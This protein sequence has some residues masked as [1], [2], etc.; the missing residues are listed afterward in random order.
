ML[1]GFSNL[2]YD[3]FYGSLLNLFGFIGY[4]YDVDLSRSKTDWAMH[5]S[6]D[7]QEESVM[8]SKNFP[9]YGLFGTCTL[10]Y[11]LQTMWR[12]VHQ[13]PPT[14]Q[15]MRDVINSVREFSINEETGG[16]A[17]AHPQLSLAAEAARLVMTNIWIGRLGASTTAMIWTREMLAKTIIQQQPTTTSGSGT[18]TSSSSSKVEGSDGA[19]S[20]NMVAVTSVQKAEAASKI[21]KSLNELLV[22]FDS[23]DFNCELWRYYSWLYFSWTP[24]AATDGQQLADAIKDR[25]LNERQLM[26]DV[27]GIQFPKFFSLMAVDMYLERLLSS[28]HQHFRQFPK[29]DKYD[30]SQSQQQ[31]R[32]MSKSPAKEVLGASTSA[33]S[34]LKAE[35][36]AKM[37]SLLL[38]VFDHLFDDVTTI[39]V[40]DLEDEEAQTPESDLKYRLYRSMVDIG[41]D[42]FLESRKLITSN[43]TTSL[44]EVTL[45]ATLVNRVDCWSRLISRLA[46]NVDSNNYPEALSEY[47]KVLKNGLPFEFPI[48]EMDLSKAEGSINNLD[49]FAVNLFSSMLLIRDNI[50]DLP[51]SKVVE[52]GCANNS[53][54]KLKQ[55]MA[56]MLLFAKTLYFQQL[57]VTGATISANQHQRD[58]FVSHVLSLQLSMAGHRFIKP[59]TD[60]QSYSFKSLLTKVFDL[61]NGYDFYFA[62]LHPIIFRSA[63][64]ILTIFKHPV[65]EKFSGHDQ[66]LFI[67][68]HSEMG[69]EFF[70]YFS[71]IVKLNFGK[72]AF[73]EFLCDSSSPSTPTAERA[74]A[75][76]NFSGSS[77][78]LHERQNF[79]LIDL[80]EV[81][82]HRFCSPRYASGLLKFVKKLLAQADKQPDDVAMTRIISSFADK[83][84][85]RPDNGSLLYK[86][87]HLVLFRKHAPLDSRWV[88]LRM[89]L[90]KD[91]AKL[92]STPSEDDDDAIMG[93]KEIYL[94]Y[95]FVLYSIK[96]TSSFDEGVIDEM[97][98]AMLHCCHR[99]LTETMFEQS[100]NFLSFTGMFSSLVLLYSN[101]GPAA[102]NGHL[103]LVSE[104]IGW[105]EMCEDYF[106][107]TEIT[108]KVKTQVNQGR[109]RYIIES[110]YQM[111]SY[112]TD[113][114]AAFQYEFY[115]SGKRTKSESES[116]Q[117]ADEEAGGG[118]PVTTSKQSLF[119]GDEVDFDSFLLPD[120]NQ[121]TDE[122]D[123]EDTEDENLCQALCTFTTTQKEFINQHWYN[124]HTCN[125]VD[126]VGVCT[127]CAQ[128]CHRGH[129]VTYSKHGSF[130]C[131]CGGNEE[132]GCRALTPRQPST[133]TKVAKKAAASAASKE[134][135]AAYVTGGAKTRGTRFCK[136]WCNTVY[137]QGNSVKAIHIHFGAD[138]NLIFF[139]TLDMVQW[140]LADNHRLLRNKFS[141]PNVNECYEHFGLKTGKIDDKIKPKLLEQ[142]R[143]AADIIF[144]FFKHYMPILEHFVSN[145]S[146]LGYLQ[147]V[148]AK[149]TA[150]Q[151][152]WEPLS[153]E[154]CEDLAS[155]VKFG[156]DPVFDNVQITT[157]QSQAV[158]HLTLITGALVR[159]QIMCLMRSRQQGVHNLLLVA[160]D[161]NRMSVVHLN[162]LLTQV[163]IN[164]SSKKK[165]HPQKL[166]TI[167]MPFTIM[168]ISHNQLN[169]EVVAVCGLK[170]CHI[171]AIT[172][173]GTVTGHRALNLSLDT[174]NH[175]VKPMWLPDSQSELA[176]VTLDFIKIFDITR[177]SDADFETP[178]YHFVI[179]SRKIR[180]MTF[181]YSDQEE[182]E[183]QRRYILILSGRAQVYAQV[184]GAEMRGTPNYYV[185]NQLT[186]EPPCN[187]TTAA[188][189]G[190]NSL[191]NT[192]IG[193]SLYYSHT[194]QLL[195]L[196]FLNSETVVAPFTI[197]NIKRKNISRT[198]ALNTPIGQVMGNLAVMTE[199]HEMIASETGT[200]MA[201][202]NNQPL[203]QWQEV[204]EHP[205]LIFAL[206]LDTSTPVVMMVNENKISLQELNPR[207]K[208]LDLVALSVSPATLSNPVL[209]NAVLNGPQ[210]RWTTMVN[211][212]EDGSLQIY[213]A[214]N[215]NTSI[216]LKPSYLN[217]DELRYTT[218]G[219]IGKRAKLSSISEGGAAAN[220]TT[221]AAGKKTTGE[222]YASVAARASSSGNANTSATRAEPKF[223]IDFFEHCTVMNDIEFGGAD[224]SELYNSQQIK[225]RLSSATTYIA[226]TKPNGFKISVAQTGNDQMV[227]AGIRV[228]LGVCDPVR[229]PTAVEV[230]G[231]S[232]IVNINRHRWFDIPFTN[233]EMRK[234]MEPPRAF[235]IRFAPSTDV[236][237]VTIV[238]SLKVY[239]KPVTSA[240]FEYDQESSGA[241]VTSTPTTTTTAAKSAA[242]ARR[243]VPAADGDDL[244]MSHA[245]PISRV[246]PQQKL[247]SLLYAPTITDDD[248]L[249]TVAPYHQ[250]VFVLNRLFA[251]CLDVLEAS[252]SFQEAA[253]H[254]NWDSKLLQDQGGAIEASLIASSKLLNVGISDRLAR[255]VCGL[256]ARL[257]PARA[258]YDEFRDERILEMTVS[259][260]QTYSP[261]D[262]IIYAHN[263]ALMRDIVSERPRNFIRLLAKTVNVA[264]GGGS[265]GSS[266]STAAS[267]IPKGALTMAT[268]LCDTFWGLYRERPEYDL[269]APVSRCRLFNNLESLI[270]SLVFI[271]YATMFACLQENAQSPCAAGK[272][273]QHSTTDTELNIVRKFT[274]MMLRFLMHGNLQIAY[275]A[276]RSLSRVLSNTNP[277]IYLRHPTER[278]IKSPAP[279]SFYTQST[280]SKFTTITKSP[281]YTTSTSTN[282]QTEGDTVYI[283]RRHNAS[284]NVPPG[285]GGE[286]TEANTAE[287]RIQ[288]T[289]AAVA[290]GYESSTSS[291]SGGL[292]RMPAIIRGRGRS[293]S[294]GTNR[295]GASHSNAYSNA[296]RRLGASN[297]G[298][299][300]IQRQIRDRLFGEGGEAA[301]RNDRNA[302]NIFEPN[303]LNYEDYRRLL[304]ANVPMLNEG[305]LGEYYLNELLN[306][307]PALAAIRRGSAASRNNNQADRQAAAPG[308]AD[309]NALLRDV[310]EIDFIEHE[311]DEEE[312][313]DEDEEGND[314]I[315]DLIE[316][317]EEDDED[318]DGNVFNDIILDDEDEDVDDDDS[319]ADAHAAR[320]VLPGGALNSSPNYVAAEDE[321]M[322]QVLNRIDNVPGGNIDEE[323]DERTIQSLRQ[324]IAQNRARLG[325]PADAA[326]ARAGGAAVPANVRNEQPNRAALHPHEEED[327]DDEDDDD[328]ED[329]EEEFMEA[330]DQAMVELAIALSLQDQGNAADND[331]A[332][333]ADVVVRTL[334]HYEAQREENPFDF[335][336]EQMEY[337]RS[338]QRDL[339]SAEEELVD[340][341]QAQALQQN[342]LLL[343]QLDDIALPPPVPEGFEEAA[344]RDASRRSSGGVANAGA[345]AAGPS[346]ASGARADDVTGLRRL[347]DILAEH[348]DTVEPRVD[349][350][351]ESYDQVASPPSQPSLQQQ[352]RQSSSSF[353]EEGE[354]NSLETS[355]SHGSEVPASASKQRHQSGGS[356]RS[357]GRR[358]AR[359]N[360]ASDVAGSSKSSLPA[361]TLASKAKKSSRKAIASRFCLTLLKQMGDQVE[362]LLTLDGLTSIPFLQVCFLIFYYY[363]FY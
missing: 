212:C 216:W 159:R 352:Q 297:G 351:N 204:P 340:L 348:D 59:G 31:R 77:S 46:E 346:G 281:K 308:A 93:M 323:M 151:S 234:L 36:I 198:T 333:A 280:M 253:Q 49:S 265:D 240:L 130:F 357:F 13:L 209:A 341:E 64:Y 39:L 47:Q 275:A 225:N 173:N 186:M 125:M 171:L 355:T 9:H 303:D 241:A 298:I 44:M 222:G 147:R 195:F 27:R 337:I 202:N 28:F 57:Q 132:G 81:T 72:C 238:D 53:W 170:E 360:S 271:L 70:Y 217:F 156:S 232:K 2:S 263:I 116:G 215:E 347:S 305:E 230:F 324:E 227:I 180:D 98:T 315:D 178:I 152:N 272:E 148:R 33:S 25:S 304:L 6:D 197:E 115:S 363:L 40:Y 344:P 30:S 189:L 338:L 259:S 231:R 174:N 185:T 66:E 193:F 63:F 131:D 345:N 257:I 32:S 149:F 38:S 26:R 150:L 317:E 288:A 86:W 91:D 144:S 208:V 260:L 105:L 5:F 20:S 235:E 22:Q 270:D 163:Y 237:N 211:L 153:V 310:V 37:S 249:S 161:K 183:E 41:A 321:L 325:L 89:R 141:N 75:G 314:E 228:N 309:D 177:E 7:D 56:K 244:E 76:D 140:K 330:D 106:K 296:L 277:N 52:T 45:P 110:V 184:L 255:S 4:Q 107:G 246:P 88:E 12:L 11:T 306:E 175:I 289:Y 334:R 139:L 85:N 349:I 299:A 95:K 221:K 129:D 203:L 82:S 176:I 264:S 146:E 290:G 138:V 322:Q 329:D 192:L 71:Q 278:C 311:E 123:D 172:Q 268:F 127:V 34:M 319:N 339:R 78:S 14:L 242:P 254:H 16:L 181:V 342:Q 224:I 114:F 359:R 190:A 143:R 206:T 284:R 10:D 65:F 294:N 23:L 196:S 267:D 293:R 145:E 158:R 214:L 84:G 124:C 269:L 154:K 207:R 331:V 17:N 164:P 118:S 18:T 117:P 103:R 97:A 60:E 135:K 101:S 134:S 29:R 326:A 191:S 328:D 137:S 188:L 74:I 343:G 313:E 300:E 194:M 201:L 213:R 121:P 126:G 335:H 218:T 327:V 243:A 261:N 361:A 250:G 353:G 61:R 187:T 165:L 282:T 258:T 160:H 8:V 279:A 111:L 166:A 15:S 256:L 24:N 68:H 251:S 155:P 54:V 292:R 287:A 83:L 223:P 283:R 157:E 167:N 356:V 220:T 276:K 362:K 21:E 307:A 169:N 179:P 205:G 19:S 286:D 285:G 168:N 302:Q 1:A 50:I 67:R 92:V 316:N 73:E 136:Q 90:P 252:F 99:M 3:Q 94:L 320:R 350:W 301:N 239:G 58:A 354:P 266:T 122:E 42:H 43:V 133:K 219:G 96:N 108:Q 226:C 274:T 312:D 318:V 332:A 69:E 273:Q 112:L 162:Q 119:V 35:S 336:E 104:V 109:Q 210:L 51:R 262:V 79:N 229:A 236:N 80:I 128:V 102:L 182:V 291:G 245:R 233:A 248:I 200:A 358:S 87:F 142:M 120:Q 199:V 113:I 48:V 295:R 247:R 100:D 62:A 55:L